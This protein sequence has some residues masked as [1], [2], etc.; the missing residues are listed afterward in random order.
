M[1]GFFANRTCRLSRLRATFHVVF[2]IHSFINRPQVISLRQSTLVFFVSWTGYNVEC[3][4]FTMLFKREKHTERN[5]YSSLCIV[6]FLR[7]KMLS[8]QLHTFKGSLNI[9]VK[10]EKKFI[11][12][13]PISSNYRNSVTSI[14]NTYAD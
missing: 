4:I 8:N 6:H 2:L 9:I 12:I 13:T 14:V 10:C 3:R 5:H 1:H 7:K 11:Q